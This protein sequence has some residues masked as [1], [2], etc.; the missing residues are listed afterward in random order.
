[1]NEVDTN[2]SG[3]VDFT[4]FLMAAMQKEHVLSKQKMEQAFKLF[5]NVF[6]YF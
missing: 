6:I 2:K 4:E 3:V 5:D 1:M